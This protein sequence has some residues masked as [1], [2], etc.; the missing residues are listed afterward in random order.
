MQVSTNLLLGHRQ[1]LKN[2]L[3]EYGIMALQDHEVLEYLL[4]FSIKQRDAQ[5]LAKNLIQRF[6][7]L[8]NVFSANL[9]QLMAIDGMT[10]SIANSLFTFGQIYTTAY[11][12]QTTD[13]IA[14]HSTLQKKYFLALRNKHHECIAYLAFDKDFK[15]VYSGEITQKDDSMVS[16]DLKQ[17]VDKAKSFGTK[18][19]FFGHNH[20]VDLAKPSDADDDFTYK[21]TLQCLKNGI[22]LI[23]HVIVAKDHIFSYYYSKRLYQIVARLYEVYDEKLAFCADSLEDYYMPKNTELGKG[24]MWQDKIFELADQKA[25][26]LRPILSLFELHTR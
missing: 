13:Q 19:M 16:T 3:D 10:E 25:D 2:R 5:P 20:A 1:R 22:L 9:P 17:V 6:G 8:Q 7:S 15:T 23:D 26:K 14:Y 18:Y 21:L 24:V 4:F 12:Q 11:L